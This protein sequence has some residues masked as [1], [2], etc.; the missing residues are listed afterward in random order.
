LNDREATAS[1]LVNNVRQLFGLLKTSVKGMTM[2]NMPENP[3]S[4]AVKA[5]LNAQFAFLTQFSDKMLEGVQK[6]NELNARA[7]KSMLDE[8]LASAQHMLTSNQQDP[9]YSVL[10]GQG[11]PAADKIRAYQ[12]NMQSILV[13]TQA[14][15]VKIMETYVPETTRAAQAVVKEVAQRASED[16][17]RAVQGQKEA[18]DKMTMP[19]NA[20]SE[21]S[22]P[23]TPTH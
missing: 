2:F 22:A 7:A 12:Q 5:Q 21:R 4:Q 18:L 15:I 8:S 14:G 13:E 6:M 11:Q 16:S 19:M 9:N 10:S 23:K 1:A 3:V 20:P 17:A